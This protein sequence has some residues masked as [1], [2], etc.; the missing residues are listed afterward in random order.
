[1]TELGVA[2]VSLGSI[3]LAFYTELESERWFQ[4]G[5]TGFFAAM[6]LSGLLFTTW[7]AG[8]CWLPISPSP[9]LSPGCAGRSPRSR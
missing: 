1:M 9:D 4:M 5:A 3:A 8:T 6:G 2:M 7:L